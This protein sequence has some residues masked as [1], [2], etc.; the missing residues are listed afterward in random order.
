MGETIIYRKWSKNVLKE[1]RQMNVAPLKALDLNR[2]IRV[3]FQW[4]D[5]R[6]DLIFLFKFRLHFFWLVQID[7]NVVGGMIAM[8]GW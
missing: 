7:V 8:T 4:G 2:E 3:F 1:C 6:L 5:L